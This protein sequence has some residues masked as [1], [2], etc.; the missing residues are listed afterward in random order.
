MARTVKTFLE[1]I[2]G[3]SERESIVN[4]LKALVGTMERLAGVAEAAILKGDREAAGQRPALI[5]T[6][7]EALKAAKRAKD[8]GAAY[9]GKQELAGYLKRAGMGASQAFTLAQIHAGLRPLNPGWS[10]PTTP[11]DEPMSVVQAVRDYGVLTAYDEV[12]RPAYVDP[13][14]GRPVKRLPDATAAT[15][16]T[17]QN[18][19]TDE[20][21]ARRPFMPL[22][23]PDHFARCFAYLAEHG[24]AV[25]MLPP[26]MLDVVRTAGETMQRVAA[27]LAA[28]A[29]DAPPLY[30][31][32]PAEPAETTDAPTIEAPATA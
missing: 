25:R 13:N 8:A 7:G 24:H 20:N 17:R 2:A 28:V 10:H 4:A 1:K 32:A 29:H 3:M 22:D 19:W 15:F 6:A 11:D 18:A 21:G 30:F 31:D 16:R 23:D 27:D 9:P 5:E 26:E 12:F 14:K